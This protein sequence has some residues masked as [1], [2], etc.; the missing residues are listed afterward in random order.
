MRAFTRIA[1]PGRVVFGAGTAR[2]VL[3]DEIAALGARRVLLITTKRGEPLAQELVRPFDDRVVHEFTGVRE[4]VPADVAAAALAAA[5]RSGADCLLCVGGGS[6]VGTAKAVA[7][8]CR[9]PII[10]VPTTYAGSEMTQVW[11]RTEHGDKRTGSSPDVLPRTVVYDPELTAGLPA[12][13]T[14][15]SG[16]NAL[17]HAVEA[18][19]APGAEPVTTLIAREAVRSLAAGLPGAVTDVT[20]VTDGGSGDSGTGREETLYGAYLAAAA[21]A[22]AGSG[23]HHKMCHT[24]GGSYDLPH[25]GTHAVLLPYVAGQVEAATP[26]VF[27]GLEESL[28]SGGT[29]N[30]LRA[31]AE[32]I[33]A[34]TALRD[35]GMRAQDLAEAASRVR[36]RTG[37]E[38]AELLRLA[39]DGTWEDR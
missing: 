21:F 8:E 7:L 4:H 25:A 37:A 35:I 10:A 11:G 5:E 3:A 22:V 12:S 38:V 1:L 36:A 39:Y 15:A 13:V 16:M 31:L 14:A 26:G 27:A 32:R 29:A 19:Y 2:R 23:L 34:P 17:A 28:G 30:G 24:L 6:S 33:G 9:L 20:D 18:H